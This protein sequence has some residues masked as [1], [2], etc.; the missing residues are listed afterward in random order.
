MLAPV[1][2]GSF[3]PLWDYPNHLLEANI[4][5]HY[6]QPAWHY[7]EN[8]QLRPAWYLS[9]NSLTT[10]LMAGLAQVMPI[11]IA[12]H[13]VLS[14]YLT[15]FL[16]GYGLLLK[17]SD[18]FWPLILLAPVLAYHF[19]FTAGFLNYAMGLALALLS[20]E[21]Y[22]RWVEKRH[23][24]WLFLLA[25]LLILLYL[26]HLAA[27][28][29]AILILSGMSSSLVWERKDSHWRRFVP[30]YLA[31]NS[32][33]P[34]V[35]LHRPLFALFGLISP[36]LVWVAVWLFRRLRLKPAQIAFLLIMATLA[37]LAA[38]RV[39]RPWREALLPGAQY[40]LFDRLTFPL[41]L[42]T[43]PYQYYPARW[44]LAAYNL[45]L[46]AALI[47]LAGLLL[48]STL[49]AGSIRLPWWFAILI[50]SI[51]YI[52]FPSR[53]NEFSNVEP[54]I[55][56]FIALLGL[57]FVRLPS[58]GAW[59]AGWIRT[60]SAAICLLSM[61]GLLVYSLQYERKTQSWREQMSVLQPGMRVLVLQRLS[62]ELVGDIPAALTFYNSFN[63]GLNFSTVAA[64][65]N[66]GFSSK[67]F[68]N[69]PVFPQPSFSIPYYGHW[70][71]DN[72]LF[73]ERKCTG[74]RQSYDAV[75]FWEKLEP[76]AVVQLNEC[77]GP[78]LTFE[79]MAV[80]PAS[81]TA[82]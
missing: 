12:G 9:S 36:L 4:V 62:S 59:S 48:R 7:A 2:V 49:L 14:L 56:I 34:L 58:A 77:F 3:A 65:E 71:F 76:K 13:L 70:R 57:G 73:V 64:L 38:V 19:N 72:A 79:D 11:T 54:R 6:D 20:I 43:L 60:L 5:A 10:L 17:R 47:A 1:W 81:S 69:G 21:S 50:L 28:I 25:G 63:S 33:A 53:M 37:S 29:F 16:A 31:L 74:L 15:L 80:W 27:W 55:L 22:Q 82:P 42:F 18:T 75:I 67:T 66:G 30:L 45:L 40:T 39:L 51:A 35:W 24:G 32:A 26:S 78:G 23:W 52:L 44:E 46:L 68:D 41:R 61:G 8:Y